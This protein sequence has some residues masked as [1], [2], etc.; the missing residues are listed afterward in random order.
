MIAGQ[1]DDVLYNAVLHIAKHPVVLPH[2]VRCALRNMWRHVS[3]DRYDQTLKL[4]HLL[5]S[6]AASACLEPLFVLRCLCGCQHLHKSVAA[7]LDA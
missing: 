7:K 2:G 3:A 4:R 6:L 5:Q 1:D